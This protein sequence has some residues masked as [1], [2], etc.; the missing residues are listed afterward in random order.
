MRKH[1]E[2]KLTFQGINFV[3]DRYQE[4]SI[5]GSI[6]KMEPKILI[7]IMIFVLLL[8]LPPREASLSSS[9]CYKKQLI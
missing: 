1:T 4:Y 5:K 3:F 7:N 9:I 6:Q 8:P 2:E